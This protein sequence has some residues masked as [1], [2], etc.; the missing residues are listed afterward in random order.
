MLEHMRPVLSLDTQG[1]G[2]L[3][4]SVLSPS[5]PLQSPEF[6]KGRD[7]QLGEI[8]KALYQG[9]RHVLIHGLRGVGKSSLAQTS[10]YSVAGNS[11]P[12]LFGCEQSTTF[13]QIIKEVF[14]QFSG[15]SPSFVS[16]LI[17]KS[18]SLGLGNLSAL[19]KLETL[20]GG[21][22]DTLSVNEAVRLLRLITEKVNGDFVV[23]VDEFDL[24]SDR[25]QQRDFT[26][27]LKQ[28]SDQ[29]IPVRF[30]VC[31]IGDSV[32]AIIDAHGSADRYF[33]TE[34][35]GQ[36]PW[37]ARYE[38]VQSAATTLGIS[39]DKNTEIRIARISDGF[40]HYIHFVCEKLFWNVFEARN[41]GVVTAELFQSAVTKAAAAMDMKLRGPYEQ[42]T[43]KYNNDYEAV[44]WAV[45]DGHELQRRSS[46][47]FESY[48]RIAKTTDGKLLD[49][50][51]FNNRINALKKEPHGSILCATRAGWYEF[52]E[53]MVRGYVRLRAEQE[54]IQLQIDHPAVAQHLIGKKP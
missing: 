20:E 14:D 24:I 22:P 32:D 43:R 1:F 7:A 53:T 44:L 13:A 21:T 36:L 5:Q 46:A 15:R 42:A 25:D 38:I 10:A 17:S 3:M 35:L 29:H 48:G 52:R 8:R 37:E 39:V 54:G 30:I 49:R 6:L 18:A 51:K 9:G 50:Q 40:P 41:E 28:V 27:L 33:H 26:N 31:G 12:I 4:G 11:D 47:I 34:S 16:E 2:R 23:V 45:A 19:A